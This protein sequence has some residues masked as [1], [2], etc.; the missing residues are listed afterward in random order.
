VTDS[1]GKA[2]GRGLWLPV[3]AAVVAVPLAAAILLVPRR[4]RTSGPAPVSYATHV[5]PLL[6]R[7]CGSCHGPEKP[8]AKLDLS[9][10]GDEKAILADRKRWKRLWDV[11]R[12]HE[13]PPEEAKLKL[14][15]AERDF[16]ADWVEE[17]LNR[18]DPGAPRDPGRVVIR[19]LNRTEYR[20]TVRDLVGIDF[21]PTGDFPS[22][23]VGYGFDNIGD[24]L[25]IPPLLLE[26]YLAAAEKVLDRAIALPDR[27]KPPSRRFEAETLEAGRGTS[28]DG[29]QQ[30]LLANA[31]IALQADV[32]QDGAYL[33][34]VR[35]GE[36]RAGPE[37]AKM[38]LKVDGAEV[39][40]FAVSA[41]RTNLQSYEEKVR[42]A[43]GK[44]RI[45]VAF[46]NDFYDPR[47]RP[48]ERDRNLVVDYVELVGPV[49]VKPA[50]PPES[51]RR[52]FTV[53]PGPGRSK[54]EAAREIL[55]RFAGRAFRR[56]VAS[57]EVERF[58]RL[59]EVADRQGDSF[60]AA[61]KVPLTALLVSPH[62]LFRVERD[63]TGPGA[64]PKGASAVG[65]FELA[66]R[67]SYFLWSTM[68][69]DE[70]FER[71]R[72]G[73]LRDPKEL[74]AQV[75]RMLADPK[76][77]ELAE[78]FAIQ[79]LQLRRLEAHQPDAG[80]FPAVTEKLRDAMRQ[81]A[82][83]LFDEV[84]RQDRSILALI[85]A[86]F[87]YLNEP[88]AR[89]YGIE[90]VKGEEMRRVGLRDERRGGVLTMAAILMVTSNPTRTSPVKRGKWVLETILG[91]P[92]PP[93]APD[94]GELKEVE[95]S[96]LTVRQRLEKHRA[97]PNCASC[98]KR[99]DPIGFAYENYDAVGAWRETEDGLPL[100]VSGTLQDGR[101]FNGPAEFRRVILARKDD[102]VRTLA[103]KMFTYALGRGVEYYD[104]PV[105][106]DIRKSLVD[107]GYRMSALVKG[108][109][110]SV[111][112]LYRRNR[113][114]E[115]KDE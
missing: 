81:E 40:T 20:N 73:K 83:G 44:R 27:L 52:I 17:A 90:G 84:L 104:A 72:A 92:P 80:K 39:R 29:F 111:P 2:G 71:A 106:R 14:P 46:T 114:S 95:G 34:R 15:P 78:N 48:S 108:V 31:E 55:S 21:D 33:V 67:L 30:V 53:A 115:V 88:L 93:P 87:T 98:H 77:R 113:A 12:A 32:A 24:V 18:P 19:R 60:E 35:A 7:Y 69:D 26:K 47:A 1:A 110:G 58:V 97:D 61:L 37:S 89:H 101:S 51:H 3:L 68:P 9:K 63:R 94:A 70:L 79:W 65:D 54:G 13:M 49:D 25:S 6:S 112:F 45:S 102:F 62:F 4:E 76:S 36:D 82:E 100:D 96:G 41:P 107:N 103:E 8:K 11:V 86:D 50:D 22:D 105:L 5:R 23:E 43:R 56:P 91:T 66:S 16:L 109:V 28:S 99:M 10:Y 59:F 85:D 38:L 74:E 75:E 57:E 42:L 64:D